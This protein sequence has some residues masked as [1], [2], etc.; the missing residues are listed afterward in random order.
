MEFSRVDKIENLHHDKCIED[1]SKVSGVNFGCIKDLTIVFITR[2]SIESA[3][4]N[5]SS[6]DSIEPLVLRMACKS[7]RIIRIRILRNEIL[8]LKYQD[9]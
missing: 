9:H 4:S 1:E 3:T 6:N 7:R 2:N 8:T 5:I